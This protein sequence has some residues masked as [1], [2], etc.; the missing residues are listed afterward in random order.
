MPDEFTLVPQRGEAFGERLSAAT[1]DLLQLGFDSFC[2]IDSDSPTVPEKAFAEAV[3][4]LARSEDSV[5]LGPSD[6][7]GY[8][9]IGLKKL[10]RRLFDTIDWSTERVFEQTID[11][12]REINLPVHLLPTWY[13][14]DDR[15]TLPR[16][17]GEFFGSN[18]SDESGFMA[19]ATRG[20]LSDL[21]EREGRDRIW[22][23]QSNP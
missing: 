18:G 20:F 11:A 14:I 4:F 21:I 1:E 10:H 16:L 19:P 2:L 13:D 5:V 17:C 7:G 9:L 15:T 3:E 23:K 8:Y 12:A 22:P 6:D